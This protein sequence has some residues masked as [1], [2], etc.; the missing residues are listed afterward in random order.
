MSNFSSCLYFSIAKFPIWLSLFLPDSFRYRCVSNVFL[1][2][3]PL[4]PNFI[5][6]TH[7]SRTQRAFMQMVDPP[8]FCNPFNMPLGRTQP[9]IKID[10]TFANAWCPNSKLCNVFDETFLFDVSI[11]GGTVISQ[12]MWTWYT[13]T[14]LGN[15]WLQSNRDTSISQSK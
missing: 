13:A 14:T 2:V 7:V 15:K 4:S 10:H 11:V 5:A 6:K 9:K 12:F 8:K 1:F 3:K